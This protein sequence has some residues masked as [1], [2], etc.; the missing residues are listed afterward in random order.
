[1]KVLITGAFGLVGSDLG[2]VLQK[3]Y[4][5]DNVVLLKHK[6][7]SNEKQNM[8]EEGSVLAKDGIETIIKKHNIKEIYHLA[9]IMSA[10]SEKDPEL[11]FNLNL[12]GLKNILDLSVKHKIRVFS[13]SSIA[14]FGPNTPKTNT[15]QHTILEPTGMYGICKLSG[16]LLCQY[17]HLKYGLDV[18][19]V[20]YPGL[21]GYKGAPGAGTTEYAIH[22]FYSAIKDK[23]YTCFLKKDTVLPMM[24]IDDAVA[25][26]M[27]IMK[28][29][30]D[31]I[32]L[33]MSYNL[34]ALSFA[35][36]DL[37]AEIQKHIPDFICSYQ[38]DYRQAI[39]DSW[40]DGVDDQAARDEWGWKPSYDLDSMTKDM[41]EKLEEKHKKG[42]I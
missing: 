9:T 31:K 13:P 25:A 42:L 16:E 41:L 28:A 2:G 39:A 15:P 32:K 26:A 35:P 36:K 3:K 37:V 18:R 1:M 24:F 34:S 33:R 38:P 23:K 7:A 14:V 21:L 8:I 17:Y 20:R 19:G 11:G 29:D 4:G 30:D 22:I 12:I 10:G 40:P 5:H 6:S 27:Q